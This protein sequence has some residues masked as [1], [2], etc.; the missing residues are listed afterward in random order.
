M[1][2]KLD[3]TADQ[4]LAQIDSRDY[5]IPYLASGKKIVKVGISFSHAYRNI[6]DWKIQEM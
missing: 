1:E 3:G 6:S 4:A 2:F 5:P